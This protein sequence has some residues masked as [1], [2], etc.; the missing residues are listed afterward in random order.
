[1]ELLSYARDS[2]CFSFTGIDLDSF[3]FGF[4]KRILHYNEVYLS[5]IK[6][7]AKLMANLFF[8]R[9]RFSAR[10]V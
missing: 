6:G 2:D 3:Y 4:N 5:R 9:L 8:V 1:M 10:V 7:L